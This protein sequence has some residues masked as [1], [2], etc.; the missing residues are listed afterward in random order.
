MKKLFLLAVVCSFFAV[1]TVNAQNENYYGGQKGSWAI[2]VGADPVI[3][4]VGNMFNG[5]QGN[6]LSGLGAT[7]AGKY[8]IGDKIALTA[9]VRFNNEINK[10]FIPNPNDDKEVIITNSGGYREFS[11]NVGAQYYFRPGKRLQ[12]F[13][14]ADLVFGRNNNNLTINKYYEYKVDGNVI[15]YDGK[16]KSSNP[17]NI[18]GCY[19]KIGVECFLSK[20]VSI[21]AALDLGVKTDTN[22]S[23]EKYKTEDPDVTKEDLDLLNKKT[24]D[25]R[26]TTFA[27]GS[28][29]AFNFY[30]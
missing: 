5:T 7:L 27:T 6:K 28:N 30:F 19:A 9:G 13:V 11:L 18:F 29:I 10:S 15:Q 25:S 2:T 20:S 16:S 23:V 14:A 4:F 1:G 3:N 12:P 17:V 8:F 26:T 21:S 22:K 24:K